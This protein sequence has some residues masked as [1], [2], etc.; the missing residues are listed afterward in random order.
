MGVNYM[1]DD[2]KDVKNLTTEEV[3]EL[4][5]EGKLSFEQYRKYENQI[6]R[7]GWEDGYADAKLEFRG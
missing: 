2:N 4:V 1:S 5:K 6:Y 3:F 7:D